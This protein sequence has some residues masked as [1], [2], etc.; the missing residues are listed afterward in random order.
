MFIITLQTDSK[1]EERQDEKGM[2]I[3][4]L[5]IILGIVLVIGGF[6]LV[7]FVT[8]SRIADPNSMFDFIGFGMFAAGIVSIWSAWH[9]LS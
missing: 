9:K 4:P 2:E 1:E 5:L 3:A 7:A 6:L 8:V